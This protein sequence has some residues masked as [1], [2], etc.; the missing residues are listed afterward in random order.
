[1]GSPQPAKHLIT[2]AGTNGKGSIVSYISNVLQGLGYSQ[3]SYTSP[4]LLRYN[5]RVRI[6]GLEAGDDI[7]LDAFAAVESSRNTV[8]LTYFEFGTLAAFHILSNA[9]LDFGVLEVGLGGRLDAVNILDGDCAVISP[10]GLDH[11]EY[12]GGDRESIG[13]EK[14]GIIRPGKPLVCGEAEPPLSVL[15]AAKNLDAPV[16]RL[17]REFS[18]K[19]INSGFRFA[20][21]GCILNIPPPPLIGQ[22]QVNNIA[23]ALAAIATIIPDVEN[24]QQEVAAAISGVILPGR[25]EAV[26]KSPLVFVDVGHNPMAAAAVRQA[27]EARGINRIRCVLAM[28]RDKNAVDVVRALDGLVAGWYCA[29]LAGVRGQSGAQLAKQVQH[30]ADLT[31]VQVFIRVEDAVT[32]A[33]ADSGPGQCTLVFGSFLAAAKAIQHLENVY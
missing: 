1:M 6:S 17:G 7:L 27:L 26:M 19:P 13:F 18:I 5:E 8:S 24:R 11:Q 32:D 4:H 20:M 15:D 31:E 30:G 25:L 10:I 2:V 16:F 33:I 9:G 3:G 22:H 21:E 14:A 28:L 12:L 29:G 23:T